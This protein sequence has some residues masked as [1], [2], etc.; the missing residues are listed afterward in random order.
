MFPTQEVGGVSRR[1]W[2]VMPQQRAVRP[3]AERK[4]SVG[5]SFIQ[6]QHACQIILFFFGK[7]SFMEVELIYG[8]VLISAVPQ[9]DSVIHI[10]ILFVFPSMVVYHRIANSFPCKPG[11]PCS[12]ILYII[13]SFPFHE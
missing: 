10:Y 4:A 5:F 2:W 1:R 7:I 8:A 6:R 3:G 13:V 12:S 9:R 11:G